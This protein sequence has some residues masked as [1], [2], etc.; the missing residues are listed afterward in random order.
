MGL[1]SNLLPPMTFFWEMRLCR[2]KDLEERNLTLPDVS[3]NDIAGARMEI[4]LLPSMAKEP[5]P[6]VWMETQEDDLLAAP[7]PDDD[8][9]EAEF[10]ESW[11]FRDSLCLSL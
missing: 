6:D 1:K 2:R 3:V 5:W 4:Q 11:S 8:V 7:C 9:E 10:A